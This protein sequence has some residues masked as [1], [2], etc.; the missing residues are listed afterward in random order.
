MAAAIGF[1]FFCLYW[2][3]IPLRL[4]AATPEGPPTLRA[5]FPSGYGTRIPRPAQS[6]GSANRPRQP[7]VKDFWPDLND[8]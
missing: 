6:M 3:K 8:V 2:G 7:P 1:G 5:G 4:A